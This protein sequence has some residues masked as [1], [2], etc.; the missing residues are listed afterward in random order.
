MSEH[1]SKSLVSVREASDLGY[2]APSTL[3]GHIAAGRLP[4]VRVGGGLRIRR[5]DL[6]AFAAPVRPRSTDAA[7]D[8]AVA[9]LVAAAPP[10]TVD[11]LDTVT[12][13]FGAAVKQRVLEAAG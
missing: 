7:I 9:A 5:A 8:A 1:L 13:A 11:Q 10:L 6:E 4:A 3:R 12:T 2:G